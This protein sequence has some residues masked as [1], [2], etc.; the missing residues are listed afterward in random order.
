M[1]GWQVRAVGVA[2][3]IA[4]CAGCS[5]SG[6]RS[7]TPPSTYATSGKRL[8]VELAPDAALDGVTRTILD[9][10]QVVALNRGRYGLTFTP[11]PNGR[12]IIV[13]WLEEPTTADRERLIG[14]IKKTP[15]VVDVRDAAES[16]DTSIGQAPRR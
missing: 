12:R 3:L 16:S 1:R 7:S 6:G 15:G 2:V 11:E 14:L 8:F 5:D 4:A 13:G 10:P 9:D